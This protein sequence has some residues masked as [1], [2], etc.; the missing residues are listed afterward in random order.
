MSS[1][2]TPQHVDG[3][4]WRSA[5]TWWWVAGATTLVT[6]VYGTVYWTTPYS[7][8]DIGS[9]TLAVYAAAA[10]PVVVLRALG[11]APFLLSAAVSPAGLVGVVIVRVAVD[12]ST[13]PTS[14]SLWPFEIVIAGVVGA[15]WGL[16]AAGLGELVLRLRR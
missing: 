14:H 6:L 1:V 12:V 10:L 2:P 7:D 16:V 13:D 8:L 9:V 15:F 5:S 3:P 4:G 11:V